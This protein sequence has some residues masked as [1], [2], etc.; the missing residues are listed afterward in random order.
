[1][2]YDL[3]VQNM[4]EKRAHEGNSGKAPK[5]ANSTTHAGFAVSGGSSSNFLRAT[6]MEGIERSVGAG[7]AALALGIVGVG[8][9]IPGGL[10]I[11]WQ[12]ARS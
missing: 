1:M 5:R 12:E 10:F 8:L 7:G 9:L 3:V 2:K 6:P 11:G 4:Q